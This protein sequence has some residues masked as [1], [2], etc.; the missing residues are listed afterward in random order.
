MAQ[1]N[2]FMINFSYIVFAIR[3]GMGILFIF[4]G[5][6]KFAAIAN[7]RYAVTLL[8]LFY[9]PVREVITFSIPTIEIILGIL[10]IIGLFTDFAL[11]HLNILLIGF[12]YISFHAMSIKLVEGCECLGQ[13]FNLKYD[14]N[15]IILIFILFLFN[16][17]VFFDRYKIWTLDR[18]FRAKKDNKDTGI[19]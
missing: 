13:V 17:I 14:M 11:V 12:T 9:F 7:F 4:S 10:L 2:K 3:I 16:I 1:K 19:I 8:K 6:S 5:I 15:H 18:Y